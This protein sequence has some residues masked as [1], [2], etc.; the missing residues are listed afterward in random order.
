MT[1]RVSDLQ[2][3]IDLDSIRNFCDVLEAD[4]WIDF[5]AFKPVFVV[6]VISKEIIPLIE[7]EK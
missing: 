1:L 4:A 3:D 5:A 6:A 7:K 2:S